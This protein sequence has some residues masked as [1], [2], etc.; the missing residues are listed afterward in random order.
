MVKFEKSIRLLILGFIILVTIVFLSYIFR[1]T[2][3]GLYLSFK[4]KQITCLSFQDLINL[5]KTANPSGYIGAKLR[6]QLATSYIVNKSINDSEPVFKKRNYIRLAHWNIQRGFNLNAIKDVFSSETHY[7]Y[8]YKDKVSDGRSEDFRKELSDI[9]N[10]D[11]ILL[12]EVDVGLPRTNYKN[13]A[14]EIAEKIGYNYA[15]ATEFIELSPLIYN[16]S[17]DS[18]NYLGLHG[19]AILSRYPIKRAK[20][21][22]LPAQY[23]WYSSEIKK[24][25]PIEQARRIGAKKIFNQEILTEVRHGNRCALVV[26]IELPNKEII[27]VVSAHL[28]DRCYPDHRFLQAKYLFDNLRYVRNPLIIGGDFNTSGTDAAPTSVKKEFGK[29]VR[30]RDF[31]ARQIALAIIPLGIPI[32][33]LANVA[34]V[35]LGKIFQYKDPTSLNIPVLFPNQERK[36]FKYIK[37]F[38]FADGEM[39]DSGGER[40]S[41]DK[42]GLF[43]NSNER[44]LKGF[45]STFKLAE[46]RVIAYFKLDWFFV[47]PK[48]G[49][50][51]PFNAQTLQLVNHVYPGRVSDH[52]PMIVDLSL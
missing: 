16:H 23:D 37:D 15:F 30:D 48:H 3:S 31:I 2:L 33:G 13:V 11:V 52:E 26:D 12:N 46:P 6:K 36:L 25:S 47:K 17:V 21:I 34:S 28:E 7:Y 40:S 50:F 51:K 39:F 42:E 49:R 18:K 29:R 10:S 45:E 8:A 27:T 14:S 44:Q 1:E 20:I 24:Q 22:R 38:K 5:S 19:N 9:K 35:A 41:N 4:A 32:P 43:A